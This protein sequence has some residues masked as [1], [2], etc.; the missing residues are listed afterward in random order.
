MPCPLSRTLIT[1][2]KNPAIIGNASGSVKATPLIGRPY[3]GGEPLT[4]SYSYVNIRSDETRRLRGETVTEDPD[5]PRSAAHAQPS[6]GETRAPSRLIFLIAN[7]GL[8]PLVSHRKQI[9]LRISNRK[10]MAILNF[11]CKISSSSRRG[12]LTSCKANAA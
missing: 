8:E 6:V 10:W 2:P 7:A 9:P 5:S 1:R 3:P 11:A 12:S 4:I